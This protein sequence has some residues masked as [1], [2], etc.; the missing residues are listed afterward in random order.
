MVFEQTSLTLYLAGYS[1]DKLEAHEGTSLSGKP[2]K[3]TLEVR[4]EVK[5]DRETNIVTKGPDFE[6]NHPPLRSD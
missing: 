6:E 1:S 2:R 3:I 5:W 4:R